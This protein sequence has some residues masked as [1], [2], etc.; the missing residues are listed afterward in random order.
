MA[1][2]KTHH[3]RK[4]T[5]TTPLVAPTKNPLLDNFTLPKSM[6]RLP[7]VNRDVSVRVLVVGGVLLLAIGFFGWTNKGLFIAGT[8][9]NQPIWRFQLENKM[10]SRYG[11]Q[12]MEELVNERLIG[13]EAAK[14]NIVISAA[15][16]DTKIAEIEKTLDGKISLT[17]ALS[18]QGMT[19]AEFKEQVKLQLIVEKMTA[20]VNEVSDEEI[21]AYLEQNKELLIATD[22][23]TLRANAKDTILRDK[24]NNAFRKIFDN[25]KGQAKVMKFF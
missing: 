7:L 9:N 19:L 12:T 23:A 24:K 10:L 18:Q 4:V 14:R 3:S 11:D 17:E 6:V 21:A 25:L 15:E 2:K 22:E 16:V 8:V 20:D 1:T 13:G 5:T